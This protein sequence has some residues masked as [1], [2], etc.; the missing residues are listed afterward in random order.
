L[1][2]EGA[3][4]D[5]T[6]EVRLAVPVTVR[7]VI[8][9]RLAHL[10]AGC[11]QAL[12]LASV[13]GREF[14][15]DAL[16]RMAGTSDGAVLDALDEASAARVV[17]DVDGGAGRVRFAHLLIRDTLYDGINAARRT[18]V[19]RQ[20]VEALEALHGSSPRHLAELAH[21]A[22]AGGD[23]DAGFG[24]ARR[25]GERAHALLAYEEAARLYR[26][27]LDA[28][29]RSGRPE[30]RLRCHVLLSLGEAEGQAGNGSDAKRALL[31]AAAIARHHGLAHELASAAAEYGGRILYVRGADDDHVLP[32]LE[33][34]LAA[35]ADDDVELRVRL[36]ARLAGALRDQPSRTQ[37]DALSRTAVELARRS[38]NHAALAYA[39][40]GR[41]L[42]II[43]PDTIAEVIAIGAELR[44]VAERIGDRERVIHGHM[45]QFGPL[46]MAADLAQAQASLD[47]AIAVAHQ[48]RQP[49]HLWDVG[50]AQ[51]MFAVATGPLDEAYTLVQQVRDLGERVQ[52]EIA[53]PVY[54]LQWHTLRDF[55]GG[56][57]NIEP[58]ILDL[59]ATRPARPVFR[60]VL[61]QL[62]ARLQR[63]G[64]AR[65]TL[66]DFARDDFS[67]LPFDQEWLLGISLL[68]ETA[69]LL[70]DT[71]SAERLYEILRPWEALNVVDQCEAIRGSVA[72]YLGLLA[73]TTRRWEEAE[74]H[75]QN[76]VAMNTRMGFRP[77]LAHSQSDYARMLLVRDA[78]H[79]RGRA[80]QLADSALV[81]YRELGMTTHVAS[82]TALAR[83]LGAST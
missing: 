45:H 81:T 14:D 26:S 78:P 68:A 19:H 35:I 9:R 33:D 62:H 34:A 8:A 28:L 57:E 23:F 6:A 5:S 51:A 50:G 29:E 42:A 43:A 70:D 32:L 21:H 54:C 69:A 17:S 82:T 44:E 11:R 53:L 61:A 80:R 13:I 65:A 3:R 7:D 41:A 2:V 24:Y 25:A 74:L 10:S 60:C 49:A 59:V 67:A 39:L 46:L 38:D 27:A 64:E 52:P 18:R 63:P 36:L 76:A 15:V 77:W 30:E 73:T 20:V 4:Q 37:R 55:R 83:R 58:A 22:I 1:E 75:F 12:V 71:G 31:E 40:D 56:L 72:R 16:A 48:L 79:D 47:A 66:E